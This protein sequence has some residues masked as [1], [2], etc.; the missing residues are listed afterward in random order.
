MRVKLDTS[1]RIKD[2]RVEKRLTMEQPAELAGLS[3]SAIG[4]YETRTSA[5]LPLQNWRTSW[6][7]PRT[8]CYAGQKT[9]ITQT[10]S[11]TLY[12]WVTMQSKY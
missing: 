2:L 7:C 10:Q 8:I 6:A 4:K 11:R 9:K 3:S 1:E 5:Y 12:T